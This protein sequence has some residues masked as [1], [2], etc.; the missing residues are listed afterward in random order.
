MCVFVTISFRWM[1]FFFVRGVF[2]RKQ[3]SVFQRGRERPM[4]IENN[5]PSS[6]LWVR[7]IEAYPVLYWRRHPSSKD[8]RSYLKIFPSR[9][10]DQSENCE[11]R[12]P[13]SLVARR[14]L[15]TFGCSAKAVWRT[16]GILTRIWCTQRCA[17]YTRSA[18]T[19]TQ[20][21]V[22]RAQQLL[23]GCGSFV[24]RGRNREKLLTEDLCH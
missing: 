14:T 11:P 20:Q 17:T 24:I 2:F 5:R 9:F 6:G 21:T 15:F 22:K 19:T 18:W 8:L 1:L 13:L 12:F 7:P 10:V 23:F 16:H 4:V 3:V